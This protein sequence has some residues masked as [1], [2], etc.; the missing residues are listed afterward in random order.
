MSQCFVYTFFFVR[1]G[2]WPSSLLKETLMVDGNDETSKYHSIMGVNFAACTNCAE[3]CI[4]CFPGWK[5]DDYVAWKNSNEEAGP[6]LVHAMGV[7]GRP[8]QTAMKPEMIPR[9]SEGSGYE[10]Y[11]KKSV[12]NQNQVVL[13]YEKMPSSLRLQGYWMA[14]PQGKKLIFLC[15]RT[16]DFKRKYPTCKLFVT[17]RDDVATVK[18]DGNHQRQLFA[19][20][21][22]LVHQG[23][24]ALSAIV[25]TEGEAKG[26]NSFMRMGNHVPNHDDLM[27]RSEFLKGKHAGKKVG[28]PASKG[29]SLADSIFDDADMQEVES[30][31]DEEIRSI[32]D[33]DNEPES[34]TTPGRSSGD[35]TPSVK[36][37]GS[38]TS[39]GPDQKKKKKVEPAVIQ[40]APNPHA[41]GTCEYWIHEL[42]FELAFDGDFL[43]HPLS[44]AGLLAPKLEQAQRDPLN[45]RMV[46]ARSAK[47]IA[48]NLVGDV[49]DKD[50]ILFMGGFS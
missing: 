8:D 49:C 28:R 3:F 40:V 31:G 37:S 11:E 26:L 39:I 18:M 25:D 43:G 1:I 2:P 4:S 14:T 34:T 35:V 38:S 48:Y 29:V 21:P 19:L 46:L 47:T 41:K 50:T 30:E 27:K 15:E 33:P 5:F 36:R 23:L 42:N 17:Q 20:H 44:Q 24:A 45:S 6:S 32:I 13:E 22:T 10:I 12:L 7:H 16:D 9:Q